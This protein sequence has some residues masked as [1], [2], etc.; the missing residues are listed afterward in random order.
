MPHVYNKIERFWHYN[1]NIRVFLKIA[2]IIRCIV[3]CFASQ[4]FPVTKVVL[5]V[6]NTVNQCLGPDQ[7]A[8]A[9]DHEWF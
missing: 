1:R 9:Q 2:Q 7:L 3:Q 8:L 6:T 5:S 4:K